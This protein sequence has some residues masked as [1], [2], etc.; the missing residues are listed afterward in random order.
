MMKPHL[1]Y[2]TDFQSSRA[3]ENWSMSMMKPH[4]KYKTD[5]QATRARENWEHVTDETS[6]EGPD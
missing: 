2:Q 3:R 5:L 4:L 6:F 1:K